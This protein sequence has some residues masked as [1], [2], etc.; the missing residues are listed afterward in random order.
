MAGSLVAVETAHAMGVSDDLWDGLRGAEP[1]VVEKISFYAPIREID[2]LRGYLCEPFVS[3]AL[4][5]L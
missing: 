2:N 5:T 1:A 3:G 4:Q